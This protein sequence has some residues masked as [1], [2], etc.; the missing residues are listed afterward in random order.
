MPS[1]MCCRL[2]WLAATV[3]E[4]VPAA[5]VAYFCAHAGRVVVDEVFVFFLPNGLFP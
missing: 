1:V 2:G 4:I 5:P 3:F